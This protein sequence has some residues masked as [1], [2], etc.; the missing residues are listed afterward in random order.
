MLAKADVHQLAYDDYVRAL[1]IDPSDAAALDGLVR[2]GDHLTQG[3]RGTMV[4]LQG[5]V[6]AKAEAMGL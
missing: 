6:I 2:D 5:T 4:R 1:A 3:R